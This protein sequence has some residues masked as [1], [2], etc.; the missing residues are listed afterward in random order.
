M[1]AAIPLQAWQQRYV[2]DGSRWKLLVKSVQVGG[3]FAA[4]LECVLDVLERA[5]LWIMLSA[6]DRQSME[7]MEKVKAHV[8]TA[9]IAAQVET[10][11]FEETS[12]VQH[13]AKF[14]NGGRIIALPANPDT[15][16]GF[17]GNVLLDEFAIHRDARAIWKAMVGRTLRGFKL[18]VVSSFKG[19]QNKFFELA[20]ALGLIATGREWEPEE[21][22]VRKGVWSGHFVSLPM[23]VRQGLAVDV[24]GLLEAVG[25][26]EIAD[27]E[28]YCIPVE[29]ALDFI[30]LEMVLACESDEATA[31]WVTAGEGLY[32]G[33]DI[34]R[35]RDLSIIWVLERNFGGLVTRGVIS[36]AKTKFRE[37][38]EMARK[39]AARAARFAV[40]ATGIGAQL[41][42]ELREEFPGVVEAV[43][44]TGPR[45]E[46]LATGLKLAMEERLIQIPESVAIRRA[47]QAVKRY[48]GTT[49]NMRFDAAR[50]DAG[51]A[52]EFWACALA[53]AAASEKT[54]VPA[55]AGG[56]VGET[57]MGRAMSV[58]G[59]ASGEMAF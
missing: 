5:G 3:S 9:G 33:F 57:V 11:F 14:P 43:E 4:S 39:V 17:S 37:Q 52:D 13:T 27:E 44:F 41:A 51:H 18:R 10:G 31:D 20:K 1:R 32:A 50:T 16:R 7:L 47:F 49:G 29:G 55:S 34:A 58:Y 8:E 15:A 21:N 12:I 54:Y 24:E 59:P 36:M 25:D 40:D 35:K 42:E 46:A 30:P 23:A 6:S 38:R 2:E 26:P 53:V 19:R 45:K 48:V 28:F 22:P 56:L